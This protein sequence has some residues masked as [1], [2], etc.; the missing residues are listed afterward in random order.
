MPASFE[1]NSGILPDQSL[2]VSEWA[3]KY[4]RLSSKASAEPGPWKTSRTPYLKEIM[5]CLSPTSPVERLAMMAGAQLGKTE[6]GNNW[7]GYVIHCSPGPMISVSPTVEMAERTSKQRIAPLIE[8]TPELTELVNPA[9]SRDSGNTVRSKEFRGGILIMT[10][11]NSATGLRSMPARYI[12]MD[13]VDAYPGDVDGEGDPVGLAEARARTFARKKIFMVS[14]PTISGSSRIEREYLSSD[15]RKYFVPCPHCGHK[16]YLEFEKLR[17]ER[18][19][20]ASIYYECSECQEHILEHHKTEM[21]TDGEWIPTAEALDG[22]TRGYHI[23]SLYSPVG[24]LSWEQIA[25][26][27]ESA[28]GS[29]ESIK[30]FKNT[31][32]GEAWVERGD[33]PQWEPIFQRSEDY[34]KA[35][36]GVLFLTAGIDIQKDRIEITVWGWG[37]K[38]YKWR[39]EHKI[40][41][42]DT[43][44]DDVWDELSEYLDTDFEHQSGSTLRIA[45]AS[46]DTG[47]ATEHVYS[48]LRRKRDSRLMAIKGVQRGSSLVGLPRSVS[49]TKLGKKSRHGIKLYLVAGP[50]AKEEFYSDLQKTIDVSEDGE[51]LYPTGYVH[52]NKDDDEFFKQICSEQLITRKNRNGY[53][54]TEWQKIRDRNEALDCYVYARAAASV[55][56]IDRFSEKHFAEF[57]SQLGF[58]VE[59]GIFVNEQ[60][61]TSKATVKRRNR[62]TRSNYM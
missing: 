23:S 53:Q 43:S 17:W 55:Y 10:G 58:D 50:M 60:N 41:H 51:V 32:L 24:W 28:Q 56:G 9:R 11:A 12:F 37:R 49:A 21:L 48:F 8:E 29:I 61:T 46:I 33:V 38:R 7:I 5:D 47:Y 13:E 52:F 30:R 16:Q 54:V 62:V 39:I 2:T 40:F 18:G 42:G 14:T 31:V 3:D 57:E 1:F 34:I 35:P 4:R 59:Q 22:K 45:K 44:R 36:L 15:Q 20:P 6:T 25:R 26:D 19:N 27:W